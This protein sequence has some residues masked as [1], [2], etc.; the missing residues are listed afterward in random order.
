MNVLNSEITEKHIIAQENRLIYRDESQ[1]LWVE[2]WGKDGI[3]VRAT[4]LYNMPE[5]DWAL[6]LQPQ[7]ENKISINEDEGCLIN[8]N[9]SVKIKN[10]GHVSVY[11]KDGKTV[12]EEYMFNSQ[13]PDANNTAA[14]HIN[15]RNFIQR[16]CGDSEVTANFKS[17]DE[18][19][20]IYGMGQYQQNFLNLKGVTLEL[21]QKNTQS[22]VPFYIS[23]LGYGFLWNNPAIG[24]VSFSKNI[25]TWHVDHSDIIDYYVTVGS[26]PEEILYNYT[27]VSGRTPIMPDYALGFWQCKLRY[28]NQDELIKIAKTYKQKNIPLSVLVVDF[29]HWTEMGDWKF[30][31]DCWPDPKMMV[32]ELRKMGI[33]I[34]VSMWPTVSKNSE[35]Y[36]IMA[37]NSLLVKTFKG[38]NLIR[39]VQG[40]EPGGYM[41]ATNPKTREFVWGKLKNNYVK[42]GITKFWADCSEPY[43]GD[44][45]LDNIKYFIG[46]HPQIGNIYPYMY[47]KTITDGLNEIGE[48]NPLLLIRCAWAGSQRLGTLT[49]S[50]DIKSTFSS[51]RNQYYAG[52]NMGMAGIPWWNT[53]I[54][55][56]SGGDIR[57]PSFKELLVRWFEFGT[58]SP[59]MRLH[60]RRLPMVKDSYINGKYTVGTGAENEVW[61]YGEEIEKILVKYIKIRETLKPYIKTLMLEAHQ[62]GSPVIRTLFYEFPDDKNAWEDNESYMFGNNILVA[63]IFFE[64]MRERNVY[65]PE[66]S[67]WTNVWTNEKYNGG[68]NI[69]ISAPLDKIP[70]FTRDNFELII[71]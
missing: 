42:Y 33:E 17:L 63:P 24:Q 36:N 58:F 14:M 32:D 56:F 20:K 27:G 57:N 29:F 28:R 12:L 65:L 45:D 35:N 23:S 21:V 68:Q 3:R 62:K 59:V 31:K 46:S 69:T 70:L 41:D 49:W 4:N 53:D 7:S 60:G 67:T 55:G 47:A 64:N 39:K 34:M 6:L 22:S 16:I 37:I 66:G 54:G 1:I 30:D 25:T 52:L 5:N 44:Y 48:K 71:D 38:T 61:S 19:E 13:G 51:L 50:G 2:P 43:Y 11:N 8:G 15:G 40:F 18:N 10:N 26:T 9:I